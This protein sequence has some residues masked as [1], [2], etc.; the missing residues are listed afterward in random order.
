MK[1][2]K[3]RCN[4]TKESR[5]AAKGVDVF[6]TGVWV[7]NGNK[8]ESPERIGQLTGQQIN[9]EIVK[10]AK[11]GAMVMHRLSA[12]HGVGINEATIEANTQ[13][14]SDQ[15]ENRLHVQKAILDWIVR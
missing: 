15:A 3:G 12:Y 5:S 2:V 9:Q 10:L 7:S 8:S 4:G 1:R 11:L 13:M 6:C 14:I